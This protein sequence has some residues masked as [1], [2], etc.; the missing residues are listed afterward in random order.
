MAF[1]AFA[2]VPA[3]TADQRP[4]PAP[5][6]SLREPDPWP[7]T[8]IPKV[9]DYPEARALLAKQKWTEAAI[10]LR[11]VLRQ[12]PDYLPASVALARALTFSNRRE[13]ALGILNQALARSKGPSRALLIRRAQTVSRLFL[14]QATLQT[15]QDGAA[16]LVNGKYRS[17]RE[18]F[19]RALK[20]E[21]DNVE[22]L[23]RLGQALVLDGDFDS[24]AERLRLAKRL[25][26]YEPEIRLWL[27]RALHQRGE[28][29]DA[30][31]ELKLADGEIEGSE[32]A[33]VW[34]AEAL[35]TSGQRAAALKAL[36]EDVKIQP[37]HVQSL[38]TLAR[39][40]AQG[41]GAGS[42]ASQDLWDARKDLQLALSRI[43]RYGSAPPRFEGELGLDLRKPIAETRG[44][45]QKHLQ[46]LDTRLDELGKE[47]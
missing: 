41:T 38:L 43:E 23:V 31:E 29:G 36:E 19:E 34:L 12:D 17:A 46:Q 4:R 42:P 8:E 5:S 27:G 21:P 28:L 1:A 26:P 6:E 9:S 3:A 10:V 24:A 33:P 44:E 25:N 7:Q 47:E 37:Y 40:R 35:S 39:L 15:F 20:T 32:L 22:V 16:F 11:S 13:E 2:H 30:I 45:A 18:K 14:T